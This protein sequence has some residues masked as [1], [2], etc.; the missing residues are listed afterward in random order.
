VYLGAFL[1]IDRADFISDFQPWFPAQAGL[2][3]TVIS[4]AVIVLYVIKVS[5]SLFCNLVALFGLWDKSVAASC[6]PAAM[7]LR[8]CALERVIL[9]DSKAFLRCCFGAQ[10]SLAVA[11]LELLSSLDRLSRSL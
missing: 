6:A 11:V 5:L 10:G 4:T 7:N 8:A 9:C 1:V 3:S 2:F